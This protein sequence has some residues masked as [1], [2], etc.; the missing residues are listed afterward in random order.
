MSNSLGKNHTLFSLLRFVFPTMVMMVFMSMYTMVDGIFV[1]RFVN[2]A[3]LSA[4]NIVYPICNVIIAIAIML[5]TGGSAVIAKKMG[6]NKLEEARQ[7]FTLITVIGIG[8]GFVIMFVCLVF[9]EDLIRIL[10]ANENIIDYCRDYATV[11]LYFTPLGILQAL[12]QYFFVTAGKPN[13]G[14]I[15][16][17]LGGLAN[18]VLDYV[19][20]ALWGMGVAGAAVATGI[21]M[22]IPAVAGL[23]YF[24]FFRKQTL[25]FVKP[26][27]D[28]KAIWQT[29]LNGSSEMVTNVSIAVVTFLYNMVMMRYLG[30]DGVAAITILLYA[31]FFLTSLYMGFSMGVAPIVSFHYGSKNKVQQKKIFKYCIGF[32]GVCSVLTY[33]ICNVFAPNL[34]AVFAEKGSNVYQIAMNGFRIFAVSFLFSGINIF[35]SA[36]FTAFSNGKVSAIIS[37]LRTFVFITAGLLLL[38]FIFG[39]DGAWLAMTAAEFLAML[40][41]VG[42]LIKYRKKYEYI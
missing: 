1:S 29:C 23:V 13:F 9:L 37:F 33:A 26:K 12:F 32:I 21:G 14:L 36:L 18:I 6:E 27:A 42:C 38:P 24:T 40:V 35:A 30:E 4:I 31:Q 28:G 34:T 2:T 17:I 19:F 8:I 16:T 39:L 10:G 5:A 11:F 41:S 22:A 15:L 25:Y 7:N 3:A 20:I